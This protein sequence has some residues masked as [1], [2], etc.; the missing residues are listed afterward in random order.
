MVA[1][2]GGDCLGLSLAA[3][4]GILRGLRESSV[5]DLPKDWGANTP[6]E[7]LQQL[8]HAWSMDP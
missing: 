2:N 5:M 1:N 8:A 4:R 6:G 7:I 3:K